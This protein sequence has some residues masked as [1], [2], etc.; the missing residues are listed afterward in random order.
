LINDF[1]ID[2]LKGD[3]RL[4]YIQISLDG[5][6]P[7]VHDKLRGAGSF[8]KTIF[9]IEKIIKN[10]IP[11]G[12]RTTLSPVNIDDFEN[13]IKLILSLGIKSFSINDAIPFRTSTCKYHGIYFSIPERIRA[14]QY[15]GKLNEKYP[16]VIT[17]IGGPLVLLNMCYDIINNQKN[18]DTHKKQGTLSG[19]TGI[20]N[21]VGILHDGTIVPC[22]M[23]AEF[24]MG[25]VKKDN[26]IDIWQNH[27]ILKDLRNRINIPLDSFKECMGCQYINYCTGG[28]PGVAYSL[29][30]KYNYPNMYDCFKHYIPVVKKWMNQTA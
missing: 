4:D 2:R 15:L 7:E 21:K 17:G 28:C 22:H 9:A 13:I 27:P 14:M 11:L 6:S 20:F 1:H 5:S 12:I 25:N 24:K 18:G 16:G 10:G 26:F 8:K 23:L 3:K 29:F 19:C 30:G